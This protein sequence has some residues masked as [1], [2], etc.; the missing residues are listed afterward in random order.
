MNAKS[1]AASGESGLSVAFA[2]RMDKAQCRVSVD[3][4]PFLCMQP[5]VFPSLEEASQ[6][7]VLAEGDVLPVR[8]SAELL[9]ELDWKRLVEL[10]R[11]LAVYGGFEP[12]PTRVKE[13]G[14]A[15]FEMQLK[16]AGGGQKVSVRCAPWNRWMATGACVGG[17]AARLPSGRGVRGVYVA[18]GGFSPSAVVEAQR[19][20]VELV[21]AVKLAARLNELPQEHSQVF[22]DNTTAG[23]ACVPTCPVCMRRLSRSDE[24][25]PLSRD[26]LNLPDVTYQTSDIVASPI[27]ARRLEV[28]GNCEVHFLREVQA[29]DV[30]VNGVAV[31]DFVCD[32]SLVLNP[33][34]V[35]C[36]H[37]AARSVLVRPGGELRG[38]TR[39]LQGTPEPHEMTSRFW[40]WRCL[41][42]P[43]TAA[44]GSVA[45][46]PH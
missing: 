27:A 8:W 19:A 29:Q 26:Y 18:P 20:G 3:A 9:V 25:R 1:Q 38:E 39:I 44:C 41:A 14:A 36:G 12:G 33:G 13:D 34:G 30:V 46:L 15:E 7:P 23:A 40:T 42:L 16:A 2:V 22:Y 24:E 28:L 43:Q 32:G 11:A 6:D 45:F 4:F 35:V 10:M 17:F 31:G 5:L 37:V 21:D